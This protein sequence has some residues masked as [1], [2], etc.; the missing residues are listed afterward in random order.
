M[1]AGNFVVQFAG[2]PGTMYTVETNGVASGPGWV[3]QGNYTAPTDNSAGFGIGVFQ[4]SEPA[5]G[6]GSRFYR[7]VYPSY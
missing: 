4:V 7:T 5:G 2:I 3:K 6:A 1:N